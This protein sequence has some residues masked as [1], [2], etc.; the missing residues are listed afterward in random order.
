MVHNF[1]K[2]NQDDEDGYDAWDDNDNQQNEE[3]VEEENENV[4]AGGAS[5]WRDSIAND[6][7]A[8]YQAHLQGN[9]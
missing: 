9:P 8:Q 4:N 7:W 2:L 5:A 6:M 3:N 1:I